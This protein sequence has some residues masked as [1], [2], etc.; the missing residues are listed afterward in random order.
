M[1]KL[2]DC[3]I[4]G[5]GFAGLSAGI[6]MARYNRSVLILDS[7]GGR[8]NTHEVNENYLGF[9]GGITTCKL[10]ERGIQQAEFFGAVIK[11]DTIEKI[12]KQRGV[13]EASGKKGNYY[14]KTIILATGVKDL[15]PDFPCRKD[16]FG[17]SLYWC[18]TCDGFKT[19]G[20]RV[21]VVGRT[22]DA[23]ITAMQFINLTDQ[24]C[25][26]TNKPVNKENISRRRREI[27]AKASLPIIQGE[28]IR[29]E[30]KNGMMDRVI[31]SDKI[32]VKTDYLFN[33]QGSEPSSELARRLGVKTD[34][35]NFILTNNEQRTNL[36][37]V[38]AA[39][40]VTKPF[41]HQ[42]VTAAH[43][44]SAAAEAANYDLYSPEQRYP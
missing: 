1:S 24:V 14:G 15:L 34:R 37:F 11:K 39:G 5:G 13:F 32:E 40:D 7:G 36:P 19:Q 25:L 16:Y 12:G 42:I 21:A 22:D 17:K 27:L 44:G 9:P 18:L 43:E 3:L 2:Y 28:I 26:I 41:A 35:K 8:W 33:Q 20:K 30:G 23:A 4:I 31:L 29:V 6:Y 38:Y 10:H